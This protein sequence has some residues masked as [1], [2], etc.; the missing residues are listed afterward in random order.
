[1][2]L[3]LV[4]IFIS[5]FGNFFRLELLGFIFLL[6]LTF[7]G[8]V[9]YSQSWGERV[10]F[11]VFAFYVIDLLVIWFYKGNLFLIPLCLSILGF[12]MS[13]P[14][15]NVSLEDSVE[16]SNVDE[17]P[18]ESKHNIVFDELKTEEPIIEEIKTVIKSKPVKSSKSKI[19]K[20]KHSPGKYVAS[21]R[22]KYYHEPKSEWAKKIKKA[23]QVWFKN[24]KEAWDK[25]YKAHP[26]V[27]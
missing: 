7:I 20:A 21:K 19:V 24:K 3:A 22:G 5:D 27:N 10:L 14:K 4:K 13:I 23:N 12:L 18:V 25:G 11:F 17:L 8:F 1:M 2:F 9:G 26:D 16:M 15:R 6:L